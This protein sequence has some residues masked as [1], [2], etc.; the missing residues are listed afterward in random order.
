[1]NLENIYITSDSHFLHKNIIKYCN[2][3]YDFSWEGV[4]EMNEDLLKQ[5]DELPENS[6]VINCGDV[7][8]NSSTTFE[9]L[10][11]IVKRMKNGNKELWLIL[12]NHDREV[13]SKVKNF[14]NFKT[15]SEVFIKAG[16]DKVFP[17]P[18]LLEDKYLLSHEPVY[19]N[20]G[21][22][23]TNYYGHLHDTFVTTDYF[24]HECENYA[25]M[26]RVKE[27]PELTKQTNLDIDTEKLSR[28]DLTIDPKNYF[29]VCWDAHHK[30]LK[31]TDIV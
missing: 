26:E 12:G 22:N 21:N 14:Q 8:L 30:I 15:A 25:M 4:K 18:I 10:S 13:V 1:M 16:F 29:N 31:F 23:I 17:F 24:N 2:R 20:P 3:P 11:E 28:T 9:E 7:F 5:F 19:L 27:H 6:I